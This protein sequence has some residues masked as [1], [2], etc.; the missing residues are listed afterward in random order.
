MIKQ[1]KYTPIIGGE[2]VTHDVECSDTETCEISGEPLPIGDDSNWEVVF[3]NIE[4][5]SNMYEIL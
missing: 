1:I 2:K 3:D 5:L 4:K